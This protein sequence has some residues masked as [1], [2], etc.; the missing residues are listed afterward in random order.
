MSIQIL[1]NGSVYYR[2]G[3]YPI[4]QYIENFINEIGDNFNVDSLL[5]YRPSLDIFWI[6]DTSNTYNFQYLPQELY[7]AAYELMGIK[8]GEIND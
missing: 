5:V 1:Y 4:G 7:P 6:C 8:K 2:T 3:N